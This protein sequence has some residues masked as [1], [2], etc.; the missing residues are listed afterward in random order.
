MIFRTILA[1]LQNWCGSLPGRTVLCIV[2]LIVMG[3]STGNAEKNRVLILNSYHQGFKWTDEQT[4]GAITA[5]NAAGIDAKYYVEYMG[6][7]WTFD[8]RYFEQLR[9]TYKLKFSTIHFD[10]IIATDNDAF[11]FLLSYRNDIFGKIPVVFCGVNW[12]RQEMLSGHSLYTG[13]NEDADIALNIDLMLQL[14]PKV[15]NIYMVVDLTTTGRIV[16]QKILEILPK[17]KDKVAIHFL[18]DISLAQLADTVSRLSDDSLVFLTIFQK[19]REGTFIEFSDIAT[20]LSRKSRVPVYGLWD[21]YLGFGIVGGM[22][23][24][25]HAQGQRAGELAVRVLNGESPDAIPV[26]MKS[27]NRY[28]FDYRELE[29]YAISPASL[30]AGSVVINEPQSFYSVNKWFVWAAA[31]G[32]IL[33]VAVM[34]TLIINIRRR[35]AAE[36]LL[37]K[38][39]D[40]LELRVE[41]R[42]ADLGKANQMLLLEIA[43]RK[44]AEQRLD[45]KN[46]E[47]ELA[48]KNLKDAQSQ[49]LQREKMASIGVLAAGVA[50]EINNPMGFISSNLGSLHRYNEK[51]MTYLDALTHAIGQCRCTN[52]SMMKTE[53]DGLKVSL[54]IDFL[55]SDIPNIIQESKEGAERVKK[56]VQ[57]L[58][59]FS[60]VDESEV[61]MASIDRCIER[62]LN[63]LSNEIK[64]KASVET[65]FGGTS[66]TACNPA[67][68]G[69]VFMNIIMNAVQ[70]I[71]SN[72]RI[73]IK[74]WEE[75]N[76]I[77]VSIGDNGK[78]IPSELIDKIF[79]PFFTTKEVGT[80]TGLG[81]SISYDIVKKHHGSISV[82]SKPGEGTTFT[83]RI[84]IVTGD[85][86]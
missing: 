41:E 78:G 33:A 28:M 84:P 56:I 21:F 3:A 50:H 86:A 74:T 63:I 24:S 46:T 64:Y 75:D 71:E 30:P 6:T 59:T 26:V 66:M 12:F 44:G 39:H 82:A 83:V 38:A 17:Y 4:Q 8:K 85:Q 77:Y 36:R 62:A 40:E 34:L 81:L 37:R 49:M 29:R 52:V 19:D 69:Q 79:E 47:L 58:K 65:T 45:M 80:G 13:V 57:D 72:G 25:G 55:R 70:S 54:K 11:N 2:L 18:D 22:L 32:T 9:D 1:A 27:P 23:T 51:I 73:I 67:Q 61:K 7:K 53:L 10:L 15:K 14:H 48:N 35:M 16:H 5:L 31:M 43:E 60:R 42:T 20:A 68:L 76:L